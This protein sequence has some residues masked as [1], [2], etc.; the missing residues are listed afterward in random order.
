VLPADT[1]VITLEGLT[2][3]GSLV[4][5]D[6]VLTHQGGTYKQVTKIIKNHYRGALLRIK[7]AGLLPF[8]VT[9]N[10]PLLATPHDGSKPGYK[11]ARRQYGEQHFIASDRIK[12]YDLLAVP[13]IT[14]D[15]NVTCFDMPGGSRSKNLGEVPIDDNMLAVIGTYIADG[16]VRIDG[17]SVQFTLNAGHVHQADIIK[18]MA[19]KLDLTATEYF[20]PG[21]RIVYVYSKALADFFAASSATG[22]TTS[23]C[24]RGYWNCRLKDSC[25]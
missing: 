5:G 12:P 11:G 8:L 24:P 23:G 6:H 21:T 20:G 1:P 3:I 13:R 22:P 2:D 14:R 15:W 18:D 9:P 7:A 25:S 10:H 17:R 4:V 19:F 16:N